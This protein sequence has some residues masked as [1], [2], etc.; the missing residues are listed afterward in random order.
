MLLSSHTFLATLYSREVGIFGC[1]VYFPNEFIAMH[2][3]LFTVSQKK[4]C[5]L[6]ILPTVAALLVDLNVSEE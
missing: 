2:S 4:V 6:K 3:G 1:Q 5:S